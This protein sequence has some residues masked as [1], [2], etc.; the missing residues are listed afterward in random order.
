M[1]DSIKCKFVFLVLLLEWG[2][3]SLMHGSTRIKDIGNLNLIYKKR[4]QYT[5]TN[6]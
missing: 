6:V 1:F 4:K 3:I 5:D 2:W